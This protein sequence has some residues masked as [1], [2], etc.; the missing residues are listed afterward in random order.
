MIEILM[1]DKCIKCNLCVKVCPTNVFEKTENG[2]PVIAR[3]DDCQTCYMCELYCPVK[4]LYVAPDA[5]RDTG[6]SESE[7]EEAGL[8]GSYRRNIGWERGQ[9]P[10]AEQDLFF[11]FYLS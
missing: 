6:V 1:E 3:Q 9:K 5:E 2:Y 4:A 7:L 10:A 8:I 11:K